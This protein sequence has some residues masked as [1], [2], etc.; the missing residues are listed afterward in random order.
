MFLQLFITRQGR[1]QPDVAT[2]LFLK[3]LSGLGIPILGLFDA[4]PY[5]VEI[6]SVYT[7]GSRVQLPE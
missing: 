3:K 2:R 7:T 6:L 4:D 5:G 1:G